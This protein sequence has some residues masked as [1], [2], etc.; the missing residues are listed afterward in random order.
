MSSRPAYQQERSAVSLYIEEA[1]LMRSERER[2]STA[3]WSCRVNRK[4]PSVPL[5]F[6]PTTIEV[7]TLV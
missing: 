6:W 4:K 2:G 5:Y 7:L 1:F 3:L